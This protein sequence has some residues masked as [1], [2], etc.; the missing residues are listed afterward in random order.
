[1]EEVIEHVEDATHLGL[2]IDHIIHYFQKFKHIASNTLNACMDSIRLTPASD[3][4]AAS[5]TIELTNKSVCISQIMTNS[6]PSLGETLTIAIGCLLKAC[7]KIYDAYHESKNVRDFALKIVEI[8][9]LYGFIGGGAWIMDCFTK[10]VLSSI[11]QGLTAGAAMVFSCICGGLAGGYIGYQL[12]K[13]VGEMLASIIPNPEKKNR[14]KWIT[15]CK[16]GF[17]IA[18]IAGGIALCYF[19]PPVGIILAASVVSV[20]VAKRLEKVCFP[21]N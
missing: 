14:S 17:C 21:I 3:I 19:C 8:L 10:F 5:Q 9:A 15:I 7:V 20:I 16:W 6:L 13:F 2:L 1:M 11:V 4:I 18:G 12:G